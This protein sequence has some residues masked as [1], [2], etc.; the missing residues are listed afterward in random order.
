MTPLTR[1]NNHFSRQPNSRFP[2]PE[3]R[4]Y[5]PKR[6]KPVGRPLAKPDTGTSQKGA[7]DSPKP[8]TSQSKRGWGGKRSGA[9]RPSKARQKQREQE[10]AKA[11]LAKLQAS[12]DLKESLLRV[13]NA[14]QASLTAELAKGSKASKKHISEC[15]QGIRGAID[16]IRQIQQSES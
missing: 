6:M 9:G 12:V 7:S 8:A 5:M 2:S 3:R 10:A 13:I 4:P 15:S 11:A 14:Q 1:K 16:L